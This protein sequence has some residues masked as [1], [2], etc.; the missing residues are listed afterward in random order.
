[1][2]TTVDGMPIRW[3][4]RAGVMHAVEGCHIS[5]F[6]PV[7]ILWAMCGAADVPANAAWKGNDDVECEACAACLVETALKDG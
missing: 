5:P 4:D 3:R 6:E 1:M 2:I 7:R